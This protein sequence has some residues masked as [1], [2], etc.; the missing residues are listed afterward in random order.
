LITSGSASAPIISIVPVLA[1]PRAK[2]GI[3]SYR[4]YAL[5]SPGPVREPDEEDE[6]EGGWEGSEEEGDPLESEGAAL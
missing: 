2:M 1:I 3:S 5:N 4:P 6:E